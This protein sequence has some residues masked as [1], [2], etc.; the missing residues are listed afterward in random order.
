MLKVPSLELSP[1]L[2]GVMVVEVNAGLPINDYMR[3]ETLAV[4]HRAVLRNLAVIAVDENPIRYGRGIMLVFK[5]SQ[6]HLGCTALVENSDAPSSRV[7]R[8]R[9]NWHLAA[10]RGDLILAKAVIHLLGRGIE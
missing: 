4:V 1:Q 2:G 8:A 5:W 6:V 3:V 9:G 7:R 10:C